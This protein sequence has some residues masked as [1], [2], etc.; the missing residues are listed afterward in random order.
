MRNDLIKNHRPMFIV[1]EGLDGSGK[2]TQIKRLAQR[3]RDLGRRAY[4]TA[5][6]TTSVTGGLIRD[7]LTGNFQRDACELTG[8]F[9]ADRITH[10]VN[11][12]WGIR[13]F[14]NEGM[15][16]ICDRYYYSSF[17]Y[18]GAETNL[19]WVMDCNLKCPEIIK[20]D[21][22]IFLD[23]DPAR[24]QNRMEERAVLEIYEDS[25]EKLNKNREQF[26]TVFEQLKDS[27]TIKIVDATRS[28]EDV[29]ED[30]FKVIADFCAGAEELR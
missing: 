16:I 17:A 23:V 9:L 24:C 13:K 1:F 28:V 7:A 4:V 27:E 18:Q 22:C 30:V 12:I 5:E 25:E 2:S 29:F 11:P 8:L 20:P 15:D 10:N 14:L 26:F 6:P 21:L 19:N 3:L